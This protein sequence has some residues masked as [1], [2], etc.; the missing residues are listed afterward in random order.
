[1]D[2]SATT[3]PLFPLPL[4]VF[5]GETIA[6]HLFEPRYREMLAHCLL[7]PRPAGDFVIAHW[8]G[9]DIDPVGTAVAV[10]KIL[11]QQPDGTA[12]I[13]VEGRR[14]VRVDDRLLLHSYESARIHDFRDQTEDWDDDLATHVYGLHRQLLVLATGDE[15]PDSFYNRRE[16]LAF[17]V[18]ACS[19]L[20][21]ETQRRFLSMTD[22]NE[23]LRLLEAHLQA[24][25]PRMREMVPIWKS[26]VAS[27]AMARISAGESGEAGL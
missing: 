4:V 3:L 5:P 13:L 7:H 21:A 6:L 18:G 24:L 27:F 11:D 25:L 8:D 19:G 26:V 16:G 22:E 2:A 9:S 14:R 10:T 17:A 15:P 23:R 20:D 1:M 12:N